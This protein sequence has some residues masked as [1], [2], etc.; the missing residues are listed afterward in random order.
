MPDSLNHQSLSKLGDKYQVLT[1]LHHCGESR[2]Y[3][4]RHLELNRDVTITVARAK[5]D[6]AFLNAYAADAET[7]KNKRHPNIMPVIEGMWLDDETFAVVRARV[8][9]STLDQT[10]S[11]VG[12]MPPARIAA[13]LSELTTALIWARDVGITNRCVEPETFVFQQGNGRVLV[14]FEPSPLI[15]GDAETIEAIGRLMNGNAPLDVSEYVARLGGPPLTA[16]PVAA[17]VAAAAVAS[18]PNPRAPD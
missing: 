13:A 17:A 15:A 7:L 8:R 6:K 14:G 2:T 12:A 11:A 18:T 10:A 5:G 3:L 1:E 16:T 9:G 4:A